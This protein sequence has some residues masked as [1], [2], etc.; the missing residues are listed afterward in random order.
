[1]P[2]HAA[3][4]HRPCCSRS[5]RYTEDPAEPDRLVEQT[6]GGRLPTIG[7]SVEF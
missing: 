3:S 6:N 4:L 2:G 1:M 5:P 7:F